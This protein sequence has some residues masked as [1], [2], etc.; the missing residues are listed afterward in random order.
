MD[1]R[2]R[3]AIFGQLLSSV[4]GSSDVQYL[5]ITPTP[6]AGVGERAHVI[7][8]QNVGGR[9]EVK[10]AKKSGERKGA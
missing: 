9:S 10:E 1:P 2:N 3:E 5:I 4:S 7:T 8:V 6:L